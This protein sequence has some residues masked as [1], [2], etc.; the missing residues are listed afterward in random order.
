MPVFLLEYVVLLSK[1]CSA[2]DYLRAII[3]DLQALW[4][5][6]ECHRSN[7][8]LPIYEGVIGMMFVDCLN[9]DYLRDRA[10]DF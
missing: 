8:A 3:V 10:I 7:L 2:V 1:P 5:W 6:W 4:L 9:V